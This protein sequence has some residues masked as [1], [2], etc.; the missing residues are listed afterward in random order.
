MTPSWVKTLSNVFL[1]LLLG[2][3]S[4]LLVKYFCLFGLELWQVERKILQIFYDPII[5]RFQYVIFTIAFWVALVLTLALERLMPARPQQRTLSLSFAQDLVWF[6]YEGILHALIIASY[7]SLLRQD[8]E[9]YFS[10]LTITY[11][12]QFP[13]WM[14]FLFALLLLDF[15]YWLQHYLNHKVPLFW[16]FHQIHHSQKELN[17]F[18]DF[19]YH[20]LEYIVRQTCLVIP[21]LILEVNP[22]KIVAFAI[23]QTWYT[24]FYHGNIRTNLGPL[25]YILVTPQSH[26]IH[27]SL[28]KRHSETNFGSLFCIWDFLFRVQYAGFDEYPETGIN[29]HD[30]PDEKSERVTDLFFTPLR[31]MLYPFRVIE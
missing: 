8:Y 28:E 15:L 25:R 27:H 31:Q 4:Y 5:G 10:G 18:T 14:K 11:V 7:V 9:K 16:V 20:V 26:R 30:F 29:D 3:G 13:G 6:F 2:V 1:C 21:F 23:F 19:R 22:P 12:N 24:R 17:F